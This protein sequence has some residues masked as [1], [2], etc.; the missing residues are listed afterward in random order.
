MSQLSIKD[1]TVSNE[2][3]SA[4]MAKVSGGLYFESKDA[5]IGDFSID[6]TDAEPQAVHFSLVPAS[7]KNAGGNYDN[8]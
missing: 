3:D 8:S 5:V 2:L 1:L 4:T 6:K 7:F